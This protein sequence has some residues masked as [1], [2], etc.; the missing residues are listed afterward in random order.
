MAKHQPASHQRTMPGTGLP[1]LRAAAEPVPLDKGEADQQAHDES[2][3]EIEANLEALRAADKLGEFMDHA[4][5]VTEQGTTQIWGIK[6]APEK[7]YTFSRW[8]FMAKDNA[9]VD[10][11]VKQEAYD[12]ADVEGRR[13]LAHRFGTRYAALGPN[14]SR[15][16]HTDAKLRKAYPSLVEQLAQRF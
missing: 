2:K 15:A 6:S 1:R 7:Q 13:A 4:P 11:F 8:Y 10:L 12:A 9:V 16:P 3:A 14:H 5:Y